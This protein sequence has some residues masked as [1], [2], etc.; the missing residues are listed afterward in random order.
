MF[1]CFSIVVYKE[2][3]YSTSAF[4]SLIASLSSC[5]H[6]AHLLIHDNTDLEGW[7]INYS[8]LELYGNTLEYYHDKT[9]VG[10]SKAYNRIAKEARAKGGQWII[11]LDQDTSLPVNSTKCY[12]SA[13]CSNPDVTIKAPVLLVENRIFSPFK[14]RL[15][16][17]VLLKKVNPGIY[18]I[19]SYRIINSGL[20]VRIDVFF[21]VNGYDEAVKVDFAD[22]LFLKR[23]RKKVKFLEILP[24]KCIH[25]FSHNETDKA[26]VF[27]R[28]SIFLNDLINCPKPDLISRLEYFYVG[29]AHTTKLTLRFKSMSFFKL[30]TRKLLFDEY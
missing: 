26:K 3:F 8:H 19:N 16:R 9:N 25:N 21:E 1:L 29:L 13:I 20:L 11:F 7:K 5:N 6:T 15:G 28:Y 27:F 23:L 24:T 14:V 30:W 4:V 18:S 22:L 12:L 17:S 2:I 10:I